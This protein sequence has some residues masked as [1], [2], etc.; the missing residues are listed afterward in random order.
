MWLPEIRRPTWTLCLMNSYRTHFLCNISARNILWILPPGPGVV[1]IYGSH[2]LSSI[3]ARNRRCIYAWVIEICLARNLTVAA[4]LSTQL[5]CTVYCC[6]VQY[7]TVPCC[8]VQYST[9]LCSTLQYCAVQYSTVLCCAETIE[10]SVV[11]YSKLLC[12]VVQ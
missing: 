11:Q 8:A 2:F 4:S 5:H 10:Y 9:V 1:H 12:Y 3:S 7:I 6:D